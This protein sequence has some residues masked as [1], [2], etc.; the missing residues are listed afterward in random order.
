[1][2]H[3]NQDAVLLE[4][5][6]DGSVHAF[7]EVYH[8]YNR[9]LM[10][11]AIDMLKDE[12]KAQDVMQEFFL[13]FW[14]KKLFLKID[15]NY[16]NRETASVMKG[17]LYASIRN[18]CLNKITR[19]RKFSCV[20]PDEPFEPADPMESKEIYSLVSKALKKKVP[21]KSS[22]A[23]RLRH[24]EQKSH[25]EIAEEMNTSIQTVKNQIGTAVKILRG[26]FTPAHL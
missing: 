13:D 17:Y 9:F 23:F 14:Q 20:I 15:L 22:T 18:R 19:E 21:P 2:Q 26:Y 4:L 1:M 7:T 25:K 16:Q 8:K 12:D 10:T 24:Y 5:L 11:L 6:K 3:N